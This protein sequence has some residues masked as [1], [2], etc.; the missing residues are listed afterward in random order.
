MNRDEI[1]A[2]LNANPSCHL[3]TMEDDQPRVRGMF[4]YRA[5]EKG[6]IFHTGDFKSLYSQV[7]GNK[8]VEICFSSPDK[9]VRVE[10][11]AEITDDVKLKQEV[12]EA[13]PWLK[14]LMGQRGEDALIIFRI[15][16][17]KATVWT[18]ETTLEPKTFVSL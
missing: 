11:V 18:M 4:M 14:P 13:R 5:D 6:I 12:L 16:D 9:Q 10:G 8:K 1:L 7:K 2:F 15:T 3:A 17:C